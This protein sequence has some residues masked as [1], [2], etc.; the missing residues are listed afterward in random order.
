M[1]PSLK[2]PKPE[3]HKP[4]SKTEPKSL[5]PNSES[6]EYQSRPKPGTDSH[7]PILTA[8]HIYD[9]LICP[10]R[11]HLD[12]FNDPN[13]MDEESD[14]DRLLRYKGQL[15]EKTA[16]RELG[17]E[18]SEVECAT[19]EES[20]KETL[21]L[22]KTGQKMIYQGAISAP[23]MHG[24]PDL[25]ERI[26]GKSRLG[27]YCYV[28]IELK[29]GSAYDDKEDET[30][31]RSYGLQLSFY[32]D[33]LEKVQGVRPAV[34]RVID[35]EL[36]TVEFNLEDFRGDYEATLSDVT[37]VLSQ[38]T[39]SEPVI[40]GG[41]GECHWRSYCIAWA[42]KVDD[43]TFIR[44]LNGAKRD[45]LRSCGIRTIAELAA[46]EASKTLPSLAGISTGALRRFIRRAAVIKSG[47]P[48]LVDPIKFPNAGVELFFDI[49][50]EPL[51]CICYLYG[52]VERRDGNLRYVS[53]F[54]DSP[55]EEKKAWKE[56]WKY[57]S[58]LSDYHM[59]HYS[60]YEKTEL[61]KLAKKYRHDKKLFEKFFENSTD[62][63]YEVD[64]HTEWPSHSYSIKSVS[65]ILGFEYSDTD[66]GGLKAARWYMDYVADPAANAGLKEKI[67]KYNRQDC[68]A[69]ILLKDWLEAQSDNIRRQGTLVLE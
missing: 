32:A 49:E 2:S 22:M 38:K 37:A 67:L 48:V 56:F 65:K 54:A 9:F 50:T 6:P 15:H 4:K 40:S 53:F 36:R 19:F 31:K 10:H 61:T 35:G 62:L 44:Y 8:N 7:A 42:K 69:M 46:L 23:R 45:C 55:D 25:L 28:P 33:L 68:E 30:L 34:G 16:L 29:S 66:P 60:K 11:V 59:Y 26:R 20:V 64:R 3:S 18:V 57:V 13:L 5:K 41:C 12:A 39:M 27:S 52:V 24:R 14:F 21:R 17:L 51:E 43:L 58:G 47:K 63:Y 1:S